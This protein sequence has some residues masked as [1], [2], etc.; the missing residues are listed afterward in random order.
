MVRI[1]RTLQSFPPSKRSRRLSPHSAF[2][3]GRSTLRGRTRRCRR[4]GAPVG[5]MV[6]Y[7][8]LLSSLH[9][10]ARSLC[11]LPWRTFTLSRPLQPGLWLLRRLRPPSRA[12]AVSR[13]LCS[14]DARR[15]FPSSSMSDVIVIRSCLLYAGRLRDNM[16]TVYRPVHPPPSLLGQV[17]QPLTPVARNDASNAGSL[18]QHRSQNW[19]VNRVWFAEAELLSAGFRPVWMP[20]THACCVVLVP[21]SKDDSSG[22][23]AHTVK[24]RTIKS[25]LGGISNR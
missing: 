10:F 2:Q 23:I 17:C 5:L 3:L 14:G 4:R 19:S 15:E 12:L 9:P 16:D 25:N 11:S 1:G 6:A 20:P 7:R 13:P 21:L 24:G 18:R 22:A 8:H